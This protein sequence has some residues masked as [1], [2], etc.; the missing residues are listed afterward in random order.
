MANLIANATS[1]SFTLMLHHSELLILFLWKEQEDSTEKVLK[2]FFHNCRHCKKTKQKLSFTPCNVIV[3]V[4]ALK[5]LLVL[6]G[7]LQHH[8]T[9]F[10][11]Y[12]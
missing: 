8:K 2:C 3:L 5:P 11:T 6:T 9:I 4:I 1:H 10:W 12:Q 7:I